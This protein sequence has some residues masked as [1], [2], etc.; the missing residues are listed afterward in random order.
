MSA[1]VARLAAKTFELTDFLVNVLK[2]DAFPGTFAGKVTY[3]DCCAGLREMGVKAQPRALLAKMPGVQLSEMA[4]CET[5]CGFGGTFSIKFGEISARLA[6]NKCQNIAE[7]GRRRGRPGRPGLHAEHRGTAAPPGRHDDEGAAYCRSA[8]RRS[9]VAMQVASMHF[10]ANAHVKLNDAGLQ[11]NLKKIKTKFVEKRRQSLFELDD[12]EG[13]RD[14]ARAIR[15]RAL[16][17]LDTWLEIF[18]RNATARGATVLF[19]E[20]PADVNALL[21]EI[22][23]RHSVKKIIKSKSM[24]SEES[25]LDHAIEAAGLTV[26]ETDL[27]E[28][29][30][31]INDYEPPSHL[32][33]P[34]L[35]KSKE[36]VAELFHRKHGTPL[37]SG[38]DELCLEARGVLRGHY[39][40]ADMGISGGNFF[41]A[42]TGS[43]VLVTNEGNATLTTTLPKVHVAI[44]GIEKIVPTLEDVATLMRLLPRSATGQSISNYVDVLTGTQGRRRVPRRGAHVLHHRRQRPLGGAGERRERGA[45]LHPLRRVHESLSGLPEHRRPLLRLGLSGSDRLDPDADVRRLRRTRWNCPHASTLC[46]QCGVVCPVRIPLPDLQRKLREMEFEGNLRPWQESAALRAWSWVAQ[47]PALYGALSGIGVRLLRSLAGADGL[48]HKLP[49][50]GGWTDERDMPAP[51]GRTFRALY[52]S[53]ERGDEPPMNA[54]QH[55]SV[56]LPKFS[57][58]AESLGTENAFVVL[59]EVNALIRQGKDIVSFCIGQPDFPTPD[60]V[61]EA[62]IAA[63]RGGKH[64]YTPSAGIDELRAA[65]AHD[66]GRGAAS[67]SVRTTSSSA[68]APSRSSPT[69]SRR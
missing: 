33:G 62:A 24:V 66:L 58:R 22:A 68:R 67:T 21:L 8:G 7:L 42:E 57:R 12:F 14:A 65:A 28:Y 2:S 20:T 39:L 25:A 9:G 50:A 11:R 18:E 6:D 19:A 35:H 23:A 4:E 1:R 15:Q 31:Q 63:I 29:I 46:N 13:T 60:N 56:T 51:A 64:G 3:H 41:V 49:L 48:I 47:R 59:A 61:Q 37:K 17:N 16:D 43:V 45:A 38:I 32:I 36:E 52:R 34:A 53:A 44:S 27:G 5:C 10:K 69:R 30:L 54:S 26:V 40:T 55:N